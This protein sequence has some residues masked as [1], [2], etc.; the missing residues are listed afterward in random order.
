MSFSR[1]N[2]H[3]SGPAPAARGQGW[4]T[5][6]AATVSKD[7]ISVNRE[8]KWEVP[9]HLF[10]A[11]MGDGTHRFLPESKTETE[12][13]EKKGKLY[14][15]QL[16]NKGDKLYFVEPLVRVTLDGITQGSTIQ[17]ALQN[18]TATLIWNASNGTSPK[19]LG[20]D[21]KEFLGKDPV[22]SQKFSVVIREN[23]AYIFSLNGENYDIQITP[24]TGTATKMPSMGMSMWQFIG[25]IASIET[26]TG[27]VTLTEPV[28]FPIPQDCNVG[29]PVARILGYYPH[30]SNWSSVDQMAL[31]AW[32][33]A[34]IRVHD[35]PYW[36][37]G[38]RLQYLPNLVPDIS[39][40]P[41][42]N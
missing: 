20:L 21:I 26:R 42:F 30:G 14:L 41:T 29:M 4:R 7:T 25:E 18:Y 28:P 17:F 36:R 12:F 8:G 31:T 1:S 35:H 27:E 34:T 11:L 5:P 9:S 15:N 6:N 10:L 23:V 32:E 24:S 19:D 33:Q 40:K 39:Y 13:T 3:N 38:I 16:F 37:E 22:F 2:W